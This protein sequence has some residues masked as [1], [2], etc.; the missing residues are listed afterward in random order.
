MNGQGFVAILSSSSLTYILVASAESSVQANELTHHR[1]EIPGIYSPVYIGHR[2]NYFCC[3]VTDRKGQL[4]VFVVTWNTVLYVLEA[5]GGETQ[6]RALVFHSI[7]CVVGALIVCY[8]HI[9]FQQLRRPVKQHKQSPS[10]AIR[11]KPC[12]HFCHCDPK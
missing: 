4:L 5:P 9:I 2:V 1:I 8:R 6:S 3:W 12:C 10:Q 7:L 11:S